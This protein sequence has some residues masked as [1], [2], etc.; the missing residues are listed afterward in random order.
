VAVWLLVGVPVA[1]V[2]LGEVAAG[3]WSPGFEWEGRVRE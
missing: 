3:V 1:R 2:W